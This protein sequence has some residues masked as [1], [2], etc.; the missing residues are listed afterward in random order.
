MS[1]DP[2]D[3]R[4]FS[5]DRLPPWGRDNRYVELHQCL[6]S[7]VAVTSVT[8]IVPLTCATELEVTQA[9]GAQDP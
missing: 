3:E 8:R 7:G 1:L 5:N 6:G 4:G 2:S 9:S